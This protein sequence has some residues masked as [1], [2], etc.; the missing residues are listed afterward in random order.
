[1]EEVGSRVLGSIS[2]PKRYYNAG[3]D[4][5]KHFIKVEANVLNRQI[6]WMP[7]YIFY[8]MDFGHVWIVMLHASCDSGKPVSISETKIRHLNN[9]PTQ[10]IQDDWQRVILNLSLSHSIILNEADPQSKFDAG[11]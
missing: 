7:P 8:A 3:A 11:S 1:M 5:S 6:L 10:Q 4:H 2:C 9:L